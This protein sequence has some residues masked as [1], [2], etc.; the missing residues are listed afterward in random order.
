[1]RAVPRVRTAAPL[2]RG[3]AFRVEPCTRVVYLPGW[4]KA[5]LTRG[6][7]SRLEQ[8]V[9][10]R[11]LVGGG[12]FRTAM[13]SAALCLVAASGAL[14]ACGATV[15]DFGKG[16]GGRGGGSGTSQGGTSAPS[17][18]AHAGSQ[19]SGGTA[20]ETSGGSAGVA[21]SNGGS[22]GVA[23]SNGGSAGVA[24]SAGAAGEQPAS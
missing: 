7:I 5:S 14:N 17:G 9:T 2:K 16:A 21:A 20:G 22:A 19:P 24:A 18:G 11:Q 23:A 8:S 1:M 10:V 6:V 13:S 12:G 3:T 15:H 4:M